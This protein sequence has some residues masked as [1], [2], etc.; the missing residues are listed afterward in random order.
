MENEYQEI[1]LK[2]LIRV[3]IKKWWIIAI[4]LVI[5][6]IS[7]YLVTSYCMKPVYQAKTSLFIGKEKG[8]LGSISLGD[9]QLNS[10]LITDYREIA[11]SRL[12]AD[13]VISNLDLQ[14]DLKTFRSNLS[15]S[16]VS[17]SRLFTVNVSHINPKLA[18]DIANE[19]AKTLVEKVSEI[20]EVQN[21][22]VI[23][24]ALVPTSPI[25]PNKKLNVAIAGVLSIM[26]ALF[27][28]FLIEYFDNTVKSEED[29]EKHLGLTVIGVIP[30]FEGEER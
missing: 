12:I 27:V 29:V 3:V 11:K 17:D 26:L 28:I 8:N 14:M 22:Q 13:E 4:F 16:T 15:I 21:I 9:L 30:K 24:K 25:K 7:T 20:I 5:G 23:D 10:K 18:T 2:E 1:D 6:T 19:L